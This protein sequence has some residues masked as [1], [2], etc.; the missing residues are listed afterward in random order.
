ML[1]PRIKLSSCRSIL[2]HYAVSSS[3]YIVPNERINLK[4][5]SGGRGLKRRARCLLEEI[6][7]QGPRKLTETSVRATSVLADDPARFY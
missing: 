4:V 5:C 7:P 6:L 1:N 2:F 3:C